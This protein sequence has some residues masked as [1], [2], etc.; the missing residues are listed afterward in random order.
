MRSYWMFFALTVFLGCIGVP[1]A[2]AQTK[3]QVGEE[4]LKFVLVLTRHGVR[5]PTWTNDRLNEYSRDPWPKWEV[6][7]GELTPHGKILMTQFGTYY[8]A[9]FADRGLLSADGCSDAGAVYIGGDTDNRTIDTAHSLSQG[10]LP[11]C[12]TIIHSLERGTQDVLFHGA[13]KLGKQDVQFGLFAVAGHI[14]GDAAALLPA[15]KMPLQVM[16]QVLSGCFEAGCAVDGKKFLLKIQP[17]L[18]S[19]SGDHVAELKGPLSTAATFAENF[20]LE[21]LDGMPDAEVGWGRI[22]EAKV[23]SL[24]ALHAASSELVQRTPYI[25]RIQASNLLFHIVRTLEQA[26]DNKTVAGA[27]ASP[28]QKIVFLVGHDT[29]ISN[30]AALLDA[31]WLI[32]G[33]Q[34]DDAAP[35][36]A[37]VFELWQRPGKEDDV[38]IYYTVQTPAQMRRASPVS[39]AEP[40]AR[41]TVFIPQCSRAEEGVPCS[42]KEFERVTGAAIDKQFVR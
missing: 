41:A 17:S 29:N 34:R 25:A 15:Y 27:I 22:D 38:R 16:Q 5:S 9:W 37:L 8:R 12:G 11:G 4:R 35:G 33:Y 24:M 7:P 26:R 14:G 23:H 21:Y 1:A 2:R 32:A 28:Q 13:A 20:Q 10:L 36:G 42:W 40:P 3:S 6:E 31:H 39:L 19:G 18:N 30:V